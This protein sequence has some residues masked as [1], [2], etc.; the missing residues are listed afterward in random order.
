[1]ILSWVIVISVLVL[2]GLGYYALERHI[3]RQERAAMKKL[4]DDFNQA[5]REAGEAIQKAKDKTDE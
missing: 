4:N 2:M 1:M 3:T 5:M